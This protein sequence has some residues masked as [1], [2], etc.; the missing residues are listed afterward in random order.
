M[1]GDDNGADT[2]VLG[3]LLL[4]C[5]LGYSRLIDLRAVEQTRQSDSSLDH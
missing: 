2:R 3:S 4:F 5:E 1:A